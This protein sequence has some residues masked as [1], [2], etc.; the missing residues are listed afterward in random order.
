M[1]AGIGHLEERA[2]LS[3]DNAA[4]ADLAAALGIEGGLGD[5]D[6]ESVAIV[7]TAR[8]DFRFRVE[9]LVSDKARGCTSTQDQFGRAS[10]ALACGAATFALVSHQAL[11]LGNVNLDS[12]VAQNVLGQVERKTVSIVK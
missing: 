8:D 3:F 1:P 9:P 11:E 2:A 12:L 5:R 4:I 10:I 7:G 6:R